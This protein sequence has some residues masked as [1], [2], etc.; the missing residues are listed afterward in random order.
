MTVKYSIRIMKYFQIQ[1]EPKL[2]DKG[3]LEIFLCTLFKK[4]SYNKL[5]LLQPHPIQRIIYFL[6]I[7]N[8]SKISIQYM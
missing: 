4:V 2:T 6:E 3:N 1:D 5:E 8:E 7:Q